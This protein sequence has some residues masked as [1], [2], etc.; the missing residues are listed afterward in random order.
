MS[1]LEQVLA[2]SRGSAEPVQHHACLHVTEMTADARVFSGGHI[3][4]LHAGETDEPT[5]LYESAVAYVENPNPLLALARSY[6]VPAGYGDYDV[7]DMERVDESAYPES[8]DL[9]II[10]PE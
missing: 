4:V 1:L 9:T 6:D 3:F 8:F 5:P 7:S 2:G 10:D